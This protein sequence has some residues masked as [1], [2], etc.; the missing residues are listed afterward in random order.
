MGI[1][2]VV[3]SDS[4]PRKEIN[5]TNSLTEAISPWLEPVL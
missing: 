4:V 3:R 1:E 5:L 2:M